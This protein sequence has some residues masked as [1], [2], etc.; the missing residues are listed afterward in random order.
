MAK[1]APVDYKALYPKARKKLE[2]R[3]TDYRFL[4]SISVADTAASL[5]KTYGVDVQEARIAGLLHDW[6]KHYSD[7]ELIKRARQFRIPIIDYEDDMAALLH[8]QTGAAALKREF[9]ELSKAVLQAVARH[10]AAAPD[11][12]DLDMVVYIADMI[13][14]LRT[15]GNLTTLRAMVGKGSL[16]ELFIKA[17]EITMRHLVTRHRFIHPDSLAVWNA[18]IQRERTATDHPKKNKKRENE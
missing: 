5:A 12:S 3:L 4:H 9:P 18:Y 1:K 11:M 14:P 10:T 8:A 16:E 17:Y 7:D 13:E 6:D 2:K 15:Q